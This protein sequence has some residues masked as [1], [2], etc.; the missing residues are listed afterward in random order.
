MN[1]TSNNHP[2]DPIAEIS[3]SFSHKLKRIRK[4]ESFRQVNQ[5]KFEL[6]TKREIEIIF[7]L[8]RDLNNPQIAETLCISRYTVE[9]HRKNINR[10][11]GVSSYVQLFQ[12]ALAFDLV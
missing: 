1:T 6:L 3:S 7:L 9:Q 8:A 4:Q 11:L 12:Y 2:M 10:K 5:D